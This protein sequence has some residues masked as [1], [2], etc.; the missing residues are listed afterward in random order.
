MGQ[1]FTGG[2]CQTPAPPPPP[3]PP[4]PAKSTCNNCPD[5]YVCACDGNLGI[6][7]GSCYTLTDTNGQPLNREIGGVYQT[8]GEIGN[9]I[10]RVGASFARTC[11]LA[12][13]LTRGQ[14][15]RGL[16]TSVHFRSVRAPR[17]VTNWPEHLSLKRAAGS[18]RT[19]SAIESTPDLAGWPIPPP[20]C[21]SSQPREFLPPFSNGL[22]R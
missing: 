22:R 14:F 1:T 12:F 15:V 5:D 18:F 13:S 8:G 19:S 4:A 20:T 10:F 6:K 16:T 2:S 21:P 9:L 3:A 17:T 7:Y 11:S